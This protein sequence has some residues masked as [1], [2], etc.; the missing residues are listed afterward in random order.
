VAA[1]DVAEGVTAWWVRKVKG[2]AATVWGDICGMW[3]LPDGWPNPLRLAWAG[4]MPDRS[5][6]PGDNALMY[7]L[8]VG[9]NHMVALP[10]A[11][12]AV[13]LVGALTAVAWMVLHPARALL[14]SVW[15]LFVT[16]L[17]APDLVE[18]ALTS[19]ASFI[20]EA[21]LLVVL[22]VGFVRAM[23]RPT[24]PAP[25]PPPV[26]V[27]PQPGKP[28]PPVAGKGGQTVGPAVTA[29]AGTAQPAPVG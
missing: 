7:G 22:V 8:W 15:G 4:R 16:W 10:F 11:M 2:W 21:V 12:L 3:I 20:A 1:V 26:P 13:L 9:Y 25:A 27:K 5:R 29:P 19:V 23:L 18:A 28:G 14:G 24:P 17:W 6:V